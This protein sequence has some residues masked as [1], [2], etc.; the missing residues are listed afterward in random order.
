MKRIKSLIQLAPVILLLVLFLMACRTQKQEV[1][2]KLPN[3]IYILADDLGIG[4]LSCYGQQMFT[5]PNIDKLAEEGIRFTQHYSGSTVCAPSRS[6]LMTGQHTGHTPIRGNKRVPL[7]DS[8]VTIAEM[9]KEAGYVTG[10]FG[11]WGLGLLHGDGPDKGYPI[12]Q[13]FDVFVGYDDQG[14][15][16][17]YYPQNIRYNDSIIPLA[18]NDHIRQV[19]YAPDIIQQ[20]ALEFIEDNTT[21][22]FFLYYATIIPHAELIVPEDSIIRKF[23][24]R[25]EEIPYQ[26]E[27]YGVENFNPAGYCSQ[28]QPRAVFAAMVTRLDMYVG[29]IIQVLNDHKLL[30][31][32]IIMFASDNGTH[33]EGGHDPLYFNSSGGLRGHKR[34]LFEGGIRSPFMV[35]WPG[36]INPGRISDHISAF[37]DFMP[38]VAEIIGIPCPENIDGIS[39]LPTLLDMGEQP[40]HDY[41]YWEF[42]EQNGKQAVRKGKWKAVRLNVRENP[43]GPVLLFDLEDDPGEEND[44]SSEHPE[45]V[46][47]MAKLMSLSRVDN[48]DFTFD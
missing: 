31:N 9:L 2:K 44:I 33:L 23:E 28:I 10:I 38:T 30:D 26:G 36:T 18:G 27:D 32:T 6:V 12:N 35:F 11:K 40:E 3:I 21:S 42:H 39:F 15:A 43:D 25:F 24:G 48:P 20:R 41:L 22:P 8:T 34:D 14:L 13:G 5:T 29:Q 1:E 19:T 47:E 16:H 4:D 17:R 37:E 45:I 46:Q 7:P